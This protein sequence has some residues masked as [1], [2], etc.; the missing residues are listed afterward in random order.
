MSCAKHTDKS[1]I[2]KY[3]LHYFF[4]VSICNNHDSHSNALWMNCLLYLY[5]LM[6]RQQYIRTMSLALHQTFSSVRMTLEGVC[7]ILKKPSPW[8]MVLSSSF[9]IS[10]WLRCSAIWFKAN[11]V[12]SAL[13]NGPGYTHIHVQTKKK[14]REKHIVQCYCVLLVSKN[15]SRFE[16]I[17]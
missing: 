5:T 3:T 13:S 2:N 7:S 15:K 12:L 17:I 11:S 9:R 8:R 16:I 6:P 4:K 10:S 1:L 14:Q